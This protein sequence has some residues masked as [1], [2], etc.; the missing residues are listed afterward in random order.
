VRDKVAKLMT[1]QLKDICVLF[2]LQVSGTK[3][4][5]VETLVDFLNAP[6]DTKKSVNKVFHHLG[7][8]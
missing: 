5:L 8:C 4:S 1:A 2:G 3:D 7:L 6:W